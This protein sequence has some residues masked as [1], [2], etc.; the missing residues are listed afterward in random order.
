MSIPYRLALRSGSTAQP[1][2]D[3]FMKSPLSG[4]AHVTRMSKL[5]ASRIDAFESRDRGLRK[6]RL[7]DVLLGAFLLWLALLAGSGQA[8]AQ[9]VENHTFTNLNRRVPD[10]NGAGLSDMRSVSS[11]IAVI[12]TVRVKLN[13]AGEFNGD[14]YGYLR[15]IRG[16]TT[17]FCVLINR[18]GRV[19]A[20]LAGYGNSGLNITLDDSVAGADIHTY[21]SVTNLPAGVPLLGTWRTDGRAVDPS[22]VLDTTPRTTSLTSFSG[23][24]GSGEW[25]LFLADMESGGTNMLVSWE[26]QVSGKARPS[27]TWPAPAPL[28]YG[29]ALGAAQL[30]ASSPVA[31]SFAYNPPASTVLKSGNGQSLSVTFTPLDSNSYTPVTTNVS[32]DV[33]KAALTITAVSTNKIYG[34]PVPGFSA[35]YAGFV[36][37]DTATVL[38]SPTVLTTTALA[39]S[40][41]GAYSITAS[42]A[43]GS[44]YT[45][46][47]VGGTL[48]VAR[49]TL[50]ITAISTNKIYGAPVPGFSA[51]YAGFV[52]GDTA[53]VLTSP[54]V[55]TTTATAGSP[56]GAYPIT[57]SGAVGSNYTIAFVGSTLT[58]AKAALTITAVSTNKIYGASVP[59]FSAS[60]T[61]FVNGDTAA[62]LTSPTV[63]TTTALVGSPVGAYPITAGGAVGSNY[64]IAFVGGTLTIVKASASGLV[65]SSKNPSLPSDGVTFTFALG[66]VAPGAGTP[67]GVVQF[68]IDGANVGSPAVLAGGVA[69]Y[70]AASLSAGTHTV[71]AEFAGDGNFFGTT[72]TLSPNQSVNTPPLAGV[73]TIERSLT[74][75]TKVLV[76]TLLGNDSDADGD[77]ISF[78]SFDGVST[79]GAV[80]TRSGDWIHYTPATRLTLAD[81][82]GY[83]IADSRG[84]TNR[85]TV[86][87]VVRNDGLPSQNLAIT[88][89]GDGSFLIRFDGIPGVRY[90]IERNEDLANPVWV[91]VGNATADAVGLF[92]FIDTPPIGSPRRYYRSVYP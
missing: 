75:G 81:S 51:T 88:D 44:N 65:S 38:T 78:V 86:L 20:S 55:L 24:D 92:Q 18:P 45:I 52:N 68:K 15:H 72:N 76:G 3:Y 84:V 2:R 48:T 19:S 17:N 12:S 83:T 4:V 11:S 10:G 6:R 67:T 80:I 35:T 5:I 87:V 49:A 71:V 58:V 50:T 32:I 91:E 28:V 33:L 42:G 1:G 47:F 53:A 64:T 21:R 85:G 34:A 89:R 41:V 43:A 8:V 77:T 61:G 66:A 29:A 82:F 60:Y 40:P 59:T 14:L 57:A 9:V 54:T 69:G 26:L 7:L 22:A 36:N 62:V 23:A 30:N 73:D 74:N 46:A 79:N 39:G 70:T 90:R 25:T 56:V 13:V 31:G 27:I 63:L 16:G 37:G